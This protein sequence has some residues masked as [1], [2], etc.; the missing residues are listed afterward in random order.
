M[1]KRIPESSKLPV[2]LST[3][4]VADIQ[5]HTLL[6]PDSFSSG[7]CEAELRLGATRNQL[8]RVSIP[9]RRQ[10]LDHIAISQ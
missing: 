1:R 2:L 8:S 9:P 10:T 6:D 7:I 5:E 3:E 4:E